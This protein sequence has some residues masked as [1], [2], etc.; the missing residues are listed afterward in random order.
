MREFFKRRGLPA[1]IVS[2]EGAV[3]LILLV[4]VLVRAGTSGLSDNDPS[5]D[6]L[7]ADNNQKSFSFVAE[8]DDR[9][10]G[11]LNENSIGSDVTG[12]AASVMSDDTDAELLASG[13]VIDVDSNIT[14][15]GGVSP[16]AD[17]AFIAS[18]RSLIGTMS[19]EDKIAQLFIVA[20]EDFTG[21]QRVS[22]AGSM[23][24][25]AVSRYPV[26]G[27]VYSSANYWDDAQ[28]GILLSGI[29][30][31]ILDRTGIPCFIMTEGTDDEGEKF[32]TLS[33][34]DSD[35]AIVELISGKIQNICYDD[36]ELLSFYGF[37]SD[38]DDPDLRPVN[39]MFDCDSVNAVPALLSGADMLYVNSGFETIYSAV[40]D[41]VLNGDLPIET[42][43]DA[44]TRI[45]SY[46]LMTEE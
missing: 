28:A 42:V 13:D 7:V 1:I 36:E 24:K 4:I 22:T 18:I 2:A 12:D 14:P 15:L 21:S 27:F 39:I 17:S 46:K 43:D 45:Y 11:V 3:V 31:M 16:E 37:L 23:T 30:E 34:N 26:G 20:P 9:N 33:L 10:K 41:A 29:R 19:I 32:V 38:S 44:L 6:L 8:V 25:A 5:K 35:H 40:F